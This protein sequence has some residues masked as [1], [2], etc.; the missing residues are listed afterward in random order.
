MSFKAQNI[1]VN[2]R[3]SKALVFQKQCQTI[4]RQVSIVSLSK[5]IVFQLEEMA[6][7]D[8]QT[9]CLFWVHCQQYSV[10]DLD[11]SVGKGRS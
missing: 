11:N 5:F 8:L 3:F 2:L 4:N 10:R 7:T 6:K 1:G 9:K